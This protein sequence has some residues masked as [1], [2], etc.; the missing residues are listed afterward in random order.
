MKGLFF[1]VCLLLFSSTVFSQNLS[2]LYYWVKFKDKQNNTYS[3]SNPLQFLSQQSLNRRSNQGLVPD[4]SDLPVSPAYVDSITPYITRVV[5]SLKW[6]N[7]VV[8]EINDTSYINTI[9]QFSFVDSIAPIIT[10]PFKALNQNNNLEGPGTPVNQQIIYPDVHGI[11]YHQLNMMNGDLLH[12]MG[13]QGQGMLIAMMDNGWN[14]VDT[15]HAFDSVRPRI[16]DSW[17]FV[18]PQ[19]TIY[20]DSIADAYGTTTAHGTQTFGCVAGNI[21]YQ[22]VG[23]A[24]DASFALY[25]TQDNVVEWVM[26]EYYWDAAAERADSMGAQILSTQLGYNYF[27]D[28]IGNHTYADLNGNKTMI[29]MAGNTAASK[30]MLVFNSAGNEGEY[31]WY[32]IDAPA[33]GDSIIAV[34]AVDSAENVAAFS[35]RGPN[36][37]GRIKPDLCAQGSMAAVLIWGQP[38]YNSGTSFSC[39]I[40]AGCAACLWQAF[41]TKTAQQIKDAI[42]ISADHFWTPD[43]NHGYGIPNFYNAYLLLA[44]N[45]NGNILRLSD[46][47]AVYPSPF[48]SQLNVSLYS[49]NEGNRTIE[50]F[51]MLGRKVYG[52]QVYVRANTFEIFSLPNLDGLNEG[53]YF[54][55]IDQQKQFTHPVVKIK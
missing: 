47:A 18:D 22:Y 12:Q 42:M 20:N 35:S 23:S 54:V 50:L 28:G 29:T 53:E 24:P 37:A 46:D 15:Q 45:Y 13:Y 2:Y 49:A 51:D 25:H 41:P 30:G 40:L 44:T 16:L 14:G 34:G 7:M 1:S 27:A 11:A 31:P 38:Y 5:E 52:Q 10:Y 17:N 26:E 32:Y 9:K 8:V 4:S 33:D 39:P 3:L 48:T 19:E 43:N 36:S 6:F 21:P 55:R